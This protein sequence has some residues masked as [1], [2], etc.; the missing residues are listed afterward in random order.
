L[1]LFGFVF[2]DQ[3]SDEVA[4]GFGLWAFG[5]GLLAFAFWLLAFGKKLDSYPLIPKN[6]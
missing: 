2:S 4:F 3:L 1:D 5:F 6:D